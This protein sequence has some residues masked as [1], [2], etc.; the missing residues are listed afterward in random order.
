MDEVVGGR[1]SIGLRSD[2]LDFEDFLVVEESAAAGLSLSVA[3]SSILDFL[4]VL[5]RGTRWN[6]PSPQSHRWWPSSFS[7]TWWCVDESP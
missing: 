2:L 3:A 5:S 6:P 1:G 7:W 4:V